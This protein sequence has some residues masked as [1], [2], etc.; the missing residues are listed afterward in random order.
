M[1]GIDE[2]DL[3]NRWNRLQKTD[4]YVLALERKAQKDALGSFTNCH[5]KTRMGSNDRTLLVEVYRGTKDEDAEGEGIRYN[6]EKNIGQS[7]ILNAPVIFPI[8][9]PDDKKDDRPEVLGR[10]DPKAWVLDVAPETEDNKS[11]AIFIG[12]IANSIA[13]VGDARHWANKEEFN[14]SLD[15]I[16]NDVQGDRAYAAIDHAEEDRRLA[17]QHSHGFSVGNALLNRPKTDIPIDR[18]FGDLK[19][20]PVENQLEAADFVLPADIA[21]GL[22]QSQIDSI[23]MAVKNKV[24][25]IQGPPGTGKSSTLAALMA[26]FHEHKGEKIAGVAVQNVAVDAL[27]ASAIKRV[28][29]YKPRKIPRLVRFYSE[30]MIFKQWAAG[31]SSR[32]DSPY[33]IDRLRLEQA[34]QDPSKWEDYLA[35]RQELSTWG[36]IDDAD[37]MGKYMENT[38]ALTREVLSTTDGLFCTAASLGSNVLYEEEKTRGDYMTPGEPTGRI[39]YFYPASTVIFDEAGT[40]H[41][42]HL[43]IPV[44]AIPGACRLVLAGDS[45]QLPA[46]V[47]NPNTKNYWPDCYLERIME[48]GFPWVELNVQY[49]MHDQ[50]Y[51]HL[52]ACVYKSPIAS[53]ELTRDPSP[54]L[55]QLLAR[56]TQVVFRGESYKLESFLH[57]IDVADGK[58]ESLEAGS[59]WN[60][61]EIEAMD[62]LVRG[63][64]L[65][66]V[67]KKDIGVLIGYKEQRKLMRKKAQQNG[68]ADIF[69]IGTIDAFQG[70]EAPIMCISLV[71]TRGYPTFMGD[72]ARANVATSRQKEALYF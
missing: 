18:L 26:Y 20:D 47:A 66:G 15:P 8:C 61:A 50:L 68:W 69:Y 31:D 3:D 64:L 43:Y 71:S 32:L 56:P 4:R 38:T 7:Y 13:A 42:P 30:S 24:S 65:R 6:P 19:C 5:I 16:F 25:V 11:G 45:K 2:Q 57:F 60:T 28:E 37:I 23:V 53:H 39:K 72:R 40:V 33:H 14:V 44:M 34:Q 70:S 58:Q 52:I 36:R 49:R 29:Q 67:A 63:L 51:A 27:L 9:D 21:S 10:S 54:F 17:S 1:S 22:N 12:T 55:K 48:R 59:S 41:R 46:F 62:A 35:G